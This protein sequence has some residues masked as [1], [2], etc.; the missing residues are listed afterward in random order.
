MAAHVAAKPQQTDA[1]SSAA[2]PVPGKI[3]PVPSSMNWRG[4]ALD[5]AVIA[6]NLFLL[7][8]LARLL[9]QGGQGFL[10]PG[11]TV[12]GEVSPAVGWLFLSVFG[13]HVIGAYLKRLPR[14]ARLAARPADDA[15]AYLAS[16]EARLTGVSERTRR[17]RFQQLAPKW[18]REPNKLFI[19]IVCGLLL[20]HFTIFMMLLF[21]GWQ[22][23]WLNDWSPLFGSKPADNTYTAFFVR[24]VLIIFI[25]PL[26]T[27]LVLVGLSTGGDAPPATWRTHWTMEL[28]ADLLLYFSIIVLTLILHVLIAPRFVNTEGAAGWTLGNVLASLIPLALAFSIFYLPPRLIYLAEDYKSPWAWLTILLALLSLAYRTFFPDMTSSW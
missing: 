1:Q 28:L 18:E 24:F 6:A 10:T 4:M 26:P 17:R 15:T 8:P 20:A 27:A 16:S 3:L 21:S 22:S 12:G 5:L 25:M 13:A 11:R 19:V 9:R 2:L 14:Q 23:T 7:A